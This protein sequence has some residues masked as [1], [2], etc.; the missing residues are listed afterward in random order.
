MPS[1]TANSRSRSKGAV[2][3]GRH[4]MA[5]YIVRAVSNALICI[6]KFRRLP[7]GISLKCPRRGPRLQSQRPRS[8]QFARPTRRRRCMTIEGLS[9]R[10][11]NRRPPQRAKGVL[12]RRQN[13][14]AVSRCS[15][16][17][18]QWRFIP[19]VPA[20][21]RLIPLRDARITRLEAVAETG[22]PNSRE[23]E[24]NGR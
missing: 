19:Q 4:S 24:G 15:N 6:R 22:P 3:I 7:S 12:G 14:L 20:A 11:V 23:G 18:F 1:I 10:A 13:R 16:A 5:P 9:G 21:G 17:Y 2:I 8:L